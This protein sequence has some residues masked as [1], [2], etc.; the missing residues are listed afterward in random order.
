MDGEC[1]SSVSTSRGL[2]LFSN[3][4]YVPPFVNVTV[5][6]T[7]ILCS[8]RVYLVRVLYQSFALTEGWKE[9]AVLLLKEVCMSVHS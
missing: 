5:G 7:V 9:R 2:P 3:S 8:Y 4:T 6:T 1:R